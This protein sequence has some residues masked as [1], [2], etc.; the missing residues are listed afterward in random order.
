MPIKITPEQFDQVLF[1]E[2][3]NALLAE[4]RLDNVRKKY[5]DLGQ[6]WLH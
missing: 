3:Q 2:I 6:A 5:A 1:E 4:G